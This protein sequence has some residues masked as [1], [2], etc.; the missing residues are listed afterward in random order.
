MLNDHTLDNVRHVVTTIGVTDYA[1]LFRVTHGSRADFVVVTTRVEPR[2][3]HLLT[4]ATPLAVE[5]GF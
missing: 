4:K 1:L 5:T 2:R 3:F